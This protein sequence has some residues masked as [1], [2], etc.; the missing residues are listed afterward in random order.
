MQ[1]EFSSVTALRIYLR[2]GDGKQGKRWWQR[3]VETPLSSHLVESALAAGIPHAMVSHAQ[4]GYTRSATTVSYDYSDAPVK[5]M[6]VCVELLAPKRML[7]QFV[8]AQAQH[9]QSATLVM[10]DGVAIAD[11][12]YDAAEWDRTVDVEYIRDAED[13]YIDGDYELEEEGAEAEVRRP[14]V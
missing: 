5:T 9:L 3:M 11:E 7:E 10:M 13:R 12:F 14:N 2:R 1:Q 6:P 8:R 4:V